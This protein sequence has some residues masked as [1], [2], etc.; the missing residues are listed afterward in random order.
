VTVP[1]GVI[2]IIDARDYVSG[3]TVNVAQ[4]V[5]DAES[6]QIGT[7][8]FP[9]GAWIPSSYNI[10]LNLAS[11]LFT[12]RILG[13]GKS[14]R[15][16]LPSG[17]GT[18][19]FLFRANENANGSE[20]IPG[21]LKPHPRVIFENFA[22]FGTASPNGGFFHA[23][24]RSFHAY[25][26]Y[27]STLQNGFVVDGYC[28]INRLEGIY[29]ENMTAGGWVFQQLYPGDG[30]TIDSF[31]A[32][33]CA[34]VSLKQMKGGRISGLVSGWHEFTDCTLQLSG[35][36]LEGDGLSG[37]SPLITC[38]G[39]RLSIDGS[40]LFTGPSR[41]AIEIDDSGLARRHSSLSLH[42]ECAFVQRLDDPGSTKGDRLG[43]AVNIKNPT[44]E[45]E[46]RM[47]RVRHQI[48]KQNATVS[49]GTY[50]LLAPR[51]IT[52]NSTADEQDILTAINQRK[53]F[54]AADWELRYRNGA[55]EVDAPEPMAAMRTTRRATSPIGL[56]GAASNPMTAGWTTLSAATY[57]YKAYIVDSETRTTTGT[58]EVSVTTTTGSPVPMLS[59]DAHIAPSRLRIVR[60]TTSGVYTEWAEVPLARETAVIYD[61]GD[62]I[63]G[64]PWLTSGVPTPP[65]TNATYDGYIIRGTGNAV[66]YASSSPAAGTWIQ[67]DIAWNTGATASGK[68]GW[69]CVAGGTPG[70]WKTMADITP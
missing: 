33:A 26:I 28:D 48:F 24:A 56:T 19:D 27:F 3:S 38:R 61:Q 59:V 60:G 29:A 11:G 57:Y 55:W 25:H 40:Q 8:Y 43:V 58:A 5:L 64:C 52:P 6:N 21:S 46:V 14:T 23:T 65:T 13:D 50:E 7:L 17:M 12:Y 35:L 63:A 31:E 22:V 42:S 34:G 9:S 1:N 70:T 66:I 4:M 18:S 49:D 32:Y 54:T 67:G 30:L 69:I 51:V 45:T 2:D 36:H 41:P 16:A 44:K 53:A 37:T 47:E 20:N 62:A 39:S 10:G 68:A 15:L